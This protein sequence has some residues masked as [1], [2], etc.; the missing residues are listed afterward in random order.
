M[1]PQRRFVI[2]VG[3]DSH[4]IIK[5]LEP[6]TGDVFNARLEDYH[7]DEMVFPTLGGEKF[8]EAQKQITWNTL[9]L[10]HIDPCINQCEL[11]VK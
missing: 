1:G 10:S 4:S 3:F 9:T 5:Y 2:Y 7:F 8:P 6:L 11:E